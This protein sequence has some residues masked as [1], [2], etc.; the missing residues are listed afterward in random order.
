M[1][2]LI[3]EDDVKLCESL[4]YQLTQSL[5]KVFEARQIQKPT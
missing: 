3:I 1:R 5:F 4:S 2:I